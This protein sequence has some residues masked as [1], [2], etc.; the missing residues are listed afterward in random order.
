[1]EPFWW[2]D[3]SVLMA[4]PWRFFPDPDGAMSNGYNAIVRFAVYGGILLWAVTHNM[5]YLVAIPVVMLATFALASWYP[6]PPPR[7]GEKFTTLRDH[8]KAAG[9]H[10]APTPNNPYMN[11]QVWEYQA[12]RDPPAPLSAVKDKAD[13]WL[14]TV[15]PTQAMNRAQLERSF[16]TVPA[17]NYEAYKKIFA[18]GLGHPKAAFEG[19]IPKPGSPERPVA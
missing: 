7:T 3:P 13:A 11:P 12:P 9:A 17:D 5:L 2:N 14:G 18:D 6:A 10:T 15:D 8:W 1:M 4:H 16:Y 19:Y